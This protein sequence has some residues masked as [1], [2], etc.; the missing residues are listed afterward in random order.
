[1]NIRHPTKFPCGADIAA[2]RIESSPPS[3]LNLYFSHA[4]VFGAA[5][6]Y[7]VEART[8]SIFGQARRSNRD[9]IRPGREEPLRADSREALG[10]R[11]SRIARPSRWHMVSEGVF[12]AESGQKG[13]IS[14]GTKALKYI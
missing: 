7:A 4:A 14:T 3:S 11:R 12:G 5:N 13:R 10:A 1:M 8:R 6:F 2:T 9:R